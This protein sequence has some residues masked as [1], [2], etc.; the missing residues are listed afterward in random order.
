MA[1]ACVTCVCVY[2]VTILVLHKALAVFVAAVPLIV[3]I[4]S[5]AGILSRGVMKFKVSLSFFSFEILVFFFFV[6]FFV[7]RSLK[8][9]VTIFSTVLSTAARSFGGADSVIWNTSSTGMPALHIADVAY[10]LNNLIR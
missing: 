6:H 8:Y 3:V 9:L 10:A 2:V 4:V 7:G 1:C 5:L